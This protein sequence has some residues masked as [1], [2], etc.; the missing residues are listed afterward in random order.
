MRI[1]SGTYVVP[2]F[3]NGTITL[4]FVVDSGA[5]DVSI[6]AD[7]VMTLM[8][9]GTITESDFLGRT[10]HVLADGSE[11]PSQVFRIRSLQ[12]GSEIL[13]DVRGSVASA[14]GSLS[15][16]AVEV[17]AAPVHTKDEIEGAIAPQARPG[18]GLIVLPDN[19]S[20][21]TINSASVSHVSKFK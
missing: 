9:M 19:Q 6:P 1:E 5:T 7:V 8:R 14:Q 21:Q 2:V 20:I 10:T 3:I 4:D 15:S 18:G 16:V 17:S 11:V 12:V 13:Y